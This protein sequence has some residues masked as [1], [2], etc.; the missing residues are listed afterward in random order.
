[1]QHWIRPILFH[2]L[3][4]EERQSQPGICILESYE[5]ILNSTGAVELIIINFA[6][7]WV[8][9]AFFLSDNLTEI[10]FKTISWNPQADAQ[11]RVCLE[12]WMSLLVWNWNIASAFCIVM[13]VS[14]LQRISI[15]P[16]VN[17]NWISSCSSHLEIWSLHARWW[18]L[19]H[20]IAS[21]VW[22]QR[23]CGFPLVLASDHLLS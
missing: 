23:S 22:N 3:N 2:L 18:N 10:L 15:F 5:L 19:E 1:M 13:P 6:S 21:I 8:Q 9:N 11:Y 14:V 17:L 16:V 7:C 4:S 12:G 20:K